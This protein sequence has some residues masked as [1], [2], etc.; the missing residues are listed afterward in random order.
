MPTYR[1]VG[2]GDSILHAVA[3]AGELQSSDRWFDT[4]QGRQAYLPGNQSRASTWEMWATVVAHSRRGGWLV[5]QDN[6]LECTQ[7]QWRTLMR[8][9]VAA[10]P[11]DR[12]LLGVLPYYDAD[13]TTV[14]VSADVAAK[15]NIMVQEFAAQPVT[16]YVRWNQACAAHPEYTYDGQHPSSDGIDY[17]AAEIDRVV[18]FRV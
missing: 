6:A 17:L 8:D 12:C 9:I 11:N 14:T 3:A 18:G 2:T 4:E 13:F 15:A 7:A 5:V 10:T 16:E 1:V